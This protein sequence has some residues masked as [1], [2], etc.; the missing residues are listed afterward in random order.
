MEFLHPAMWHVA[1]GSWQW[2][3]QV[4]VCLPC[5]VTRGSGMKCHWIRQ[6]A[7]HCNVAGGSGMTCRWIHPKV[8]HIRI[9]LQVSISTI[10]R[11]RHA[12]LHQSAKFYPN[13]TTL[14][15]KKWRHVDFPKWRI[16]SILDF[17]GPIMGPLKSPCV[18][19][20][21]SSIETMA[22]NCLVFEKIAFLYFRDRQTDEQMY[23]TDVLS[24]SRCRE[25][26]LLTY[27]LYQ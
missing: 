1:L 22:L 18:T 21:R 14:G 9:L 25:R 12:I 10:S 16:S 24:R 2:I 27:L 19:S 26:R 15:R 20:Y 3:H 8:R 6:V 7:A 17:R 23:S 11:S 4:A 5:N 13:R